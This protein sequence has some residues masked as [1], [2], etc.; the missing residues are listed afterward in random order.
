M[1]KIV[2]FIMLLFAFNLSAQ[3][4]FLLKS[5]ERPIIEVDVNGKEI[6]ML[7]DTG[8]SLNVIDFSQLEDLGIKRRFKIGDV[9]CI[10]GGSVLWQ[11]FQAPI[12]VKNRQ[13]N[14]FISSDLTVIRES[15][16]QSTGI[17]IAGILGTPAIKELGMIIDLSR[18][19]VTI[20]KKSETLVSTD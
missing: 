7:I 17:K 13:V 10:A 19:I 15:I 16:L 18:G 9:M 11:I 2:L 3:N 5:Y 12:T 1:K 20:K 6:F 4:D 14:Q 8:S